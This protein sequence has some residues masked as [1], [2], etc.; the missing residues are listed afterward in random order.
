MKIKIDG[1]RPGKKC[2]GLGTVSGNNSSRLLI[3]YKYENNE[4]YKEILEYLFGAGGLAFYA[5]AIAISYMLSGYWGLYSAQQF[6]QSKLK[7][8]RYSF[9]EEKETVREE[10][11]AQPEEVKVHKK[12]GAK[13][14][15]SKRKK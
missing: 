1:S 9:N 14:K 11:S 10:Q 8:V 6:Y 15:R 3:D 5:L 4:S 2:W 7:P 12:Q 13:K